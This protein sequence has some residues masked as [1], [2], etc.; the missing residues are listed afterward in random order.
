MRVEGAEGSG[1]RGGSEGGAPALEDGVGPGDGE[2]V[3]VRTAELET[4]TA[5]D[6]A[7]AA[8]LRALAG[9]LEARGLWRHAAVARVVAGE[10]ESR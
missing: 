9:S 1:P 5:T 7:L 10:L 8:A 4:G 2:V 6:G 3:A